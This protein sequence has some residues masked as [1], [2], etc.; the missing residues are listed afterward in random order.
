MRPS[1]IS[2]SPPCLSL[3]GGPDPWLTHPYICSPTIILANL[4]IHVGS[5]RPNLKFFS[6]I[7]WPFHLIRNLGLI[8]SWNFY[9]FWVS[10]PA[11][12]SLT[13]ASSFPPSVIG[14][15]EAFSSVGPLFSQI[16]PSPLFTLAHCLYHEPLFQWLWTNDFI[17]SIRSVYHHMS[18]RVGKDLAAGK[19]WR[20]KE[21]GQQMMRWLN[22]I[23]DSVD[24][25]WA[26]FGR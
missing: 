6:E 26:N 13:V 18:L 15:V 14:F 24:M 11:S 12:C 1:C 8:I 9:V 21:M 17:W 10:V 23:T 20:Q 3:L 4:N 5:E 19:D 2:H 25:I 7:L 22:N 16:Y